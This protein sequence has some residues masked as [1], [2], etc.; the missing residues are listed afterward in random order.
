VRFGSKTNDFTLDTIVLEKSSHAIMSYDLSHCIDFKVEKLNLP[1]GA[2]PHAPRFAS[3]DCFLLLKPCR[4]RYIARS[5]KVVCG[6]PKKL[7]FRPAAKI[8]VRPS[9]NVKGPS[10]R[11]EG[12]G[13]R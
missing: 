3:G 10:L 8:P 11:A 7:D 9:P 5:P 12:S 4:C 6:G 1:I 2:K 13:Q